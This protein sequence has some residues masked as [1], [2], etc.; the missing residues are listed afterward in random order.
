[1]TLNT[2]YLY[3]VTGDATFSYSVIKLEWQSTSFFI[4]KGAEVDLYASGD[5]ESIP[6]SDDATQIA[7]KA[8]LFRRDASS[9]ADG[10]GAYYLFQDKNGYIC[11]SPFQGG[12]PSYENRIVTI[13]A[14]DV[15]VQI[16]P[17]SLNVVPEGGVRG[18]TG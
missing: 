15:N 14:W 2:R 7:D 13:S 10:F 1:M 11:W 17:N 9:A 4:P 5:G 16:L 12:A 18:T 6:W 3:K 8:L